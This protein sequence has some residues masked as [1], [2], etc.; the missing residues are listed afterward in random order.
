MLINTTYRI[1]HVNQYNVPYWWILQATAK[2]LLVYIICSY[3][4]WWWWR[5]WWWWWWW[6]TCYMTHIYM[7]EWY[8]HHIIINRLL[9]SHVIRI[10]QLRM[11]TPYFQDYTSSTNTSVPWELKQEQQKRMLAIVLYHSCLLH[12]R[13]IYSRYTFNIHIPLIIDHWHI[14]IHNIIVRHIRISYIWKRSS[15][16]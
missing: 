12:V 4:W 11:T 3:I 15:T 7:A 9:H 16:L 2:S 6:L 5:W 14:G 8:K 10:A 13:M 1:V